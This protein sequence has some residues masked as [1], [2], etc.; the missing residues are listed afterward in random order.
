LLQPNK[1]LE[2][3]KTDCSNTISIQSRKNTTFENGTKYASRV[4]NGCGPIQATVHSRQL[5]PNM[6]GLRF[7]LN[8]FFFFFAFGLELIPRWGGVSHSD[9]LFPYIVL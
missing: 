2:F 3:R 7:E 1:C 9:L 5:S 6:N 4:L 8:F